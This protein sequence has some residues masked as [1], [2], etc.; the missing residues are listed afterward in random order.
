MVISIDTTL[1]VRTPLDTYEQSLII[2]GHFRLDP[3]KIYYFSIF[4]VEEKKKL[5]GTWPGMGVLARSPSIPSASIQSTNDRKNV[6][7]IF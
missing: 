2:S 7:L 6:R 3:I 1:S 5:R 4:I